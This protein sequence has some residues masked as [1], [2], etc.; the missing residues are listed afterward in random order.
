MLWTNAHC[1]FLAGLCVYLAY[2]GL[3]SLE[4]LSHK[5]RAALGL[6]KRFALMGAAAVAATFINPYGPLFHVWLYHDLKVPR[7]EILEWRAPELLDGQFTPFWLLAAVAIA[8]L[9]VSRRSRDLTQVVVLG[10]ILWQALT[11]HRHIAFFAIACGWWLALH[12]DSLLAQLGVGQRFRTDEEL[13]YGWAPP[14]SSAFS[15]AFSPRAQQGIALVLVL[16]VTLAT[17]RLAYRLTTLSVERETYPVAAADFIAR[18]GLSGKMVCTFN[19]AQYILAAFGART[20]DDPGIRVQIDGRC[21]TSYS[22]ALLDM[23]FDFILGNLPPEE[24][25]RDPASGPFDPTRVLAYER[26]DL[27]LIS[28]LQGPSVQVMEK[29]TAEWV[30]LYQDALAQLWGR[31]SRYDDPYSAYYLPPAKREVG[32]SVQRGCVAWPA[33]PAYEPARAR[34][35]LAQNPSAGAARRPGARR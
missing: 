8:S 24:R 22:Q 5:G 14:E 34:P 33:I 16:A 20:A 23:H 13:R 3:R 10:L 29:Q 11:H 15:A 19:W 31:A 35:T 25:Y 26:P 30:L 28:R 17:G 27:V 6:V 32:Q 9:I 12:F 4:A 7:P 1:G 21:R 2:L 18:R